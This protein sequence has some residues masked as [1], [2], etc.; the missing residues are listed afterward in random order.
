V[1]FSIFFRHLSLQWPL[2]NLMKTNIF[3]LK[4]NL[5]PCDPDSMF[6]PF[7]SYDPSLVFVPFSGP[8]MV[9]SSNDDN[10]DENPTR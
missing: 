10:E 5:F 2:F 7:S 8:I 1:I 4:K 9:S 3:V 6:V